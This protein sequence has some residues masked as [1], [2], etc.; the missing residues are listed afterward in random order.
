MDREI[1]GEKLY[2]EVDGLSEDSA[3]PVQTAQRLR[4]LCEE[5]SD[6]WKMFDALATKLASVE[7]TLASILEELDDDDEDDGSHGG[8]PLETEND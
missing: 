6:D 7:G 2:Y 3:V 4:D 5:G 8:S 1:L